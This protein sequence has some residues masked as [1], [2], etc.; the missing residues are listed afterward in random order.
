MYNNV[1]LLIFVICYVQNMPHQQPNLNIQNQIPF[2][3]IFC[4]LLIRLGHYASF[5]SFL[6]LA[7]NCLIKSD[8]DF[9]WTYFEWN[10]YTLHPEWLLLSMLSDPNEDIRKLA[11]DKILVYRQSDKPA[12]VRTRILPKLNKNAKKYYETIGK[13]F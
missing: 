13:K 1:L 3:I 5:F 2:Q 10:C 4:A 7:K 9:A 12:G 8:F 6:E 11:V